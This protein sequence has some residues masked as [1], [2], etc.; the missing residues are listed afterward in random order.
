MLSNGTC[1]IVINYDLFVVLFVSLATNLVTSHLIIIPTTISDSLVYTTADTGATHTLITRS[2]LNT[3]SHVQFKKN[4]SYF[5]FTWWCFYYYFCPRCCLTIYLCEPHSYI[6]FR[7][8][9]WF[10]SWHGLVSEIWC[11]LTYS[12][13]W[14]L[15]SS[16]SLRINYLLHY[17]LLFKLY[18][19]Q[20]F[21]F[22][23]AR[24]FLFQNLLFFFM[25]FIFTIWF[26]F[27]F[28]LPTS[29]FGSIIDSKAFSP[30]SNVHVHIVNSMATSLQAHS[31]QF[32]SSWRDYCI[33][34]L[35]IVAN[36]TIVL[37]CSGFFLF[38]FYRRLLGQLQRS[39]PS[40]AAVPLTSLSTIT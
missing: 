13:A 27:S 39:S 8:C 37:L 14:T 25:A 15:S 11:L 9:C 36:G 34:Y 33:V 19:P 12:S 22:A 29:I 18:L 32:H 5:C 31:R 35:M 17:L 24:T 30:S 20:I 10:N 21:S 2:L 38:C 6:C 1:L 23:S 7:L 28:R 16:S 40:R 4:F 3:C 26:L